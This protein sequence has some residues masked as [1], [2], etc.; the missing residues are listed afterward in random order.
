MSP[1]HHLTWARA[2]PRGSERR[3]VPPS[4]RRA[5]EAIL[6]LCEDELRQR[7][8]K[9]RRLW[10]ERKAALGPIWDKEFE[11]LPRHVQAVLGKGENL[12]F[13]AEMLQAVATF[14]S[15]QVAVCTCYLSK[16]MVGRKR[17]NDMGVTMGHLRR[18]G[19]SNPTELWV[20]LVSDSYSVVESFID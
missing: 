15:I 1:A 18:G 3:A 4:L 6:A 5:A 11:R 17:R 2:L 13:L 14:L 10:V 20:V 8:E 16:G 7:R 19:K 12:L 9:Q